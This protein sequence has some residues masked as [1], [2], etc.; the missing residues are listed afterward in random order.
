MA[1]ASFSDLVADA[2][3]WDDPVPDYASRAVLLEHNA[4]TVLNRNNAAR[5]CTNIAARSPVCVAF[6]L[7]LSPGTQDLTV[8]CSGVKPP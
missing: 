5:L 6:V 1:T 2:S 8:R 7:P 3:L 4:T